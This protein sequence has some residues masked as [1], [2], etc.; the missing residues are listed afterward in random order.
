MEIEVLLR[1][2]TGQLFLI[3]TGLIVLCPLKL[4]NLGWSWLGICS[5][6]YVSGTAFLTL[7]MLF[8]SIFG[9]KFSLMVIVLPWIIGI[10]TAIIISRFQKNKGTAL[11]KP[12]NSLES[13]PRE[14][15]QT[16]IIYFIIIYLVCTCWLAITSPLSYWDALSHWGFKAKL[17]YNLNDIDFSTFE[18]HNYYPLLVPLAE[19]WLYLSIGEFNDGVV[20]F[21]FPMYFATIIISLFYFQRFCNLS[22]LHSLL[23]ILLLLFSGYRFIGHAAMGYA[24]LPLAANYAIGSFFALR[25]IE[26]H[27]E[28]G[29]ELIAAGILWGAALWT[30]TEGFPMVVIGIFVIVLFSWRILINHTSPRKYFAVFIM[31]LI[32]FGLPWWIYCKVYHLTG[33]EEHFRTLVLRPVYLMH[34]FWYL[35]LELLNISRWGII[36]WLWLF[37]IILGWKN[38]KRKSSSGPLFILIILNLFLIYFSYVVSQLNFENMKQVLLPTMPRLVIHVIPLAIFSISLQIDYLIKRRRS[39]KQ[40]K[41]KEENSC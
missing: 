24:D 2:L 9:L 10:P 17:F 28:R 31:L 38:L 35:V 5:I 41:G 27:R 20:K 25:W 11:I 33:F 26:N 18:G 34:L 16:I 6:S 30:K 13:R 39:G 22:K 32:L 15:F 21:I 14:F 37:T 8:I 4:R 29:A 19:T 40:D 3:L 1:L 23:I 12:E 7:E 36:W